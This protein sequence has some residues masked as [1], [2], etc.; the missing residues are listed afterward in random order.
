MAGGWFGGSGS[1]HRCD[2]WVTKGPA[3]DRSAAG[4]GIDATRRRPGAGRRPVPGSSVASMQRATALGP[5]SPEVRDV[6]QTL[7]S[8]RSP[9]SPQPDARW[10]PSPTGAG[11]GAEACHL[12]PRIVVHHCVMQVGILRA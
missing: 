4:I 10:T 11:V 12:F 5:A 8:D 2:G 7:M 1:V 6:R 9:G 3:E